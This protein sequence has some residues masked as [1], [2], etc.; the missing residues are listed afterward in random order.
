MSFLVLY[1]DVLILVVL[2]FFLIRSLC[3]VLVD[4]NREKVGALL[5]ARAWFAFVH[6]KFHCWFVLVVVK[7]VAE[8]L[9]PS[10]VRRNGER[11]STLHTASA[12]S[13]WSGVMSTDG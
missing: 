10:L 11:R 13:L 6:L 8:L 7:H 4:L 1:F 2:S 5:R 12:L 3:C 9:P